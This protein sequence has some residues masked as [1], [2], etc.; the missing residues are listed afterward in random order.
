MIPFFFPSFK[1]KIK[2]SGAVLAN[3]ETRENLASALAFL[4]RVGLS[5]IVIHGVGKQLVEILG[6][7]TRYPRQINEQKQ[8]KLRDTIS[9]KQIV[10]CARQES[11]KHTFKLCERIEAYGTRAMPLVRGVA[12]AEERM[13][14]SMAEEDG[15]LH[16]VS[17]Y[18]YLIF[19]V[20][21]Y[22]NFKG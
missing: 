17:S 12:I 14:G 1:K 4:H 3:A 18:L 15:L 11:E 21:V 19:F 2:V 6:S 22:S 9:S 20:F 7:T 10:S 16:L 5:P 13:Y 8:Y